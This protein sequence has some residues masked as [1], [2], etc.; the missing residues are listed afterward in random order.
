MN[1]TDLD[2]HFILTVYLEGASMKRTNLLI[3]LIASFA[4][5]LSGCSIDNRYSTIFPV[6]VEGRS[7]NPT[8]HNDEYGYATIFNSESYEPKRGDLVVLERYGD[9]DPADTI[10]RWI[11]RIIGLP[12]EKIQ[13]TDGIVYINGV[14]LDESDYLS[15]EF[16]EKI[17]SDFK[18]EYGVE[19]GPFTSDFGPVVLKDDEYYV[20]GDN[21]P[22]SKDSR[23][24]TIG[25]INRTEIS[26]IGFEKIE[27]EN[28]ERELTRYYKYL[29][30]KSKKLWL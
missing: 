11:K 14:P 10:D 18:A 28:V 24:P 5:F 30:E 2:I 15:N 27:E 29:T 1:C 12:G 13:A 23:Y 25:P 4:L 7:M 21:R 8:L 19:Y 16:Q 3:M 22:Y 9:G 26:G 6:M 20:L 17:L